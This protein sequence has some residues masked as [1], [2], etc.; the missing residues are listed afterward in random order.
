MSVP[1]MVWVWES[2]T[3][4]NSNSSAGAY[5]DLQEV[6][7]NSLLVVKGCPETTCWKVPR[8]C[9]W[10]F[11]PN[12]CHLDS[13]AQPARFFQSFSVSGWFAPL[14]PYSPIDFP[15]EQPRPCQPTASGAKGRPFSVLHGLLQQLVKLLELRGACFPRG[16]LISARID[17]EKNNSFDP[18]AREELFVFWLKGSEGG[19]GLFMSF[20][21]FSKHLQTRDVLNSQDRC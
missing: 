19:C 8:D 13:E 4:P 17:L 3:S 21:I 7:T 16:S 5:Q 12:E 10:N 11:W 20:L 18:I 1:W 9:T 14:L 6:S 15:L 2:L